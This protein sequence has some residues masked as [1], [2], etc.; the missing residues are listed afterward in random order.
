VKNN[1]FLT[2]AYVLLEYKN[3]YFPL[4]AELGLRLDHFSF[5]GQDFAVQT[6]P[7]LNPRLNLDYRLLKDKWG[8]LTLTAGTGLFSSINDFVP[9]IEK[10][11]APSNFALHPNRSW[12][13]LLGAEAEFAAGFSFTFEAYHKEVFDRTYAIDYTAGAMDELRYYFDGVGRI[14]GFDLIVQKAEGL[15]W[16]GWLSY[17]FTWTKYK[18][19]GPMFNSD[20]RWRSNWYYP[21]FQRFHYLNLVLNI[22]PSEKFKMNFRFGF[23]SGKP[24]G[25]E[26]GSSVQTTERTGFSW[27]IDMKFSWYPVKRGKVKTEIYLGVENFQSLFYTP[28]W[29]AQTQGYTGEEDASE[30]KPVYEMP[31]PM[32]S[33]GFKWT[34]L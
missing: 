17:S 25:T 11:T 7:V 19:P 9:Y 29:V 32:V 3:P 27:P 28:Q 23:A 31:V 15:H 26:K 5:L 18:E 24:E 33:F 6:T 14:F 34:G 1:G 30:Y 20:S 2:S 4:D 16:D 10:N 8:S 13:N 12:T 21:D 22:K